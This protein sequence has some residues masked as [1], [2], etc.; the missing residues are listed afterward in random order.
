[1]PFTAGDRVRV[2]GE[3][4]LVEEATAF[5]DCSLL[6]LIANDSSGDTHRTCRLLVPF[7]RPVHCFDVSTARVVSRR[8][9]IKH[10][11]QGLADTRIFGQ[12]HAAAAASM[13]IHPFQLEPA[14]ALVL[15]RASR[16]LLADEVGLGK[17][18]Q[19]GLILGEL[20]L[21]GWVERALIVTPSGLRGQWADELLR[22]FDI[23]ATIVDA[24]ALAFLKRQLPHHVNPWSAAPVCITS[25]DFI[26]Q[27]EVLHSARQQVWDIVIVDEAHQA[28]PA[29]QRY[30][31]VNAI[32]LRSRYV[33]LLTATPHDGDDAAF[34]ALCDMGKLG[35]ADRVLLFRRTRQQ[36]GLPRKR[37]VHLLPVRLTPSEIEMHRLLEHY[38]AQLWHVARRTGRAE[39]QLTAVVLSKRAFS[40]ASSLAAT[41]E[42]RLA[43]LEETTPTPAQFAL[44]FET[45]VD[46]QDVPPELSAPAFE[47][48]DQ[49]RTQLLQL[50]DAAKRAADCE[51][52]ISTIGRLLRRI[53]EPVIVFTEYRDTLAAIHSALGPARSTRLLH[54]GLP[55][56]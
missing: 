18:I 42:R 50:L 16:F 38:V 20:R 10:L 37:R 8:R 24:T 21:R 17:T 27:P 39:V 26:K 32:G 41:V 13:E 45:D 30:D 46:E 47:H 36:A 52:K 25:I 43:A 54:G 14:L 12:L 4:W 53:P 40:S 11:H 51:G 15:G 44:P 22:R 49:E 34:A 23:P 7:D 3:R 2:R 6:S 55:N 19:A 33:V 31:A 56:E 1:M 29:T 9:W 48:A 28:S 5:P 35:T